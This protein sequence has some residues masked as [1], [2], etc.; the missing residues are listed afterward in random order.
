M[1]KNLNNFGNKFLN[2]LFFILFFAAF[3]SNFYHF[4]LTKDYYYTIETPCD[5]LTELCFHRDCEAEDAE[6]PPNNY[7]YYRAFTI[8]SADYAS[9]GSNQCIDFCNS[10]ATQ[11]EETMCDEAEGDTCSVPEV[12]DTVAAETE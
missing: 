9:C 11:C 12:T 3:A 4:F 10:G 6:C 1:E 7:S 8:K 2:Y 5:P